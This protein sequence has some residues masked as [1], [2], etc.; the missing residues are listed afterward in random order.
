MNQLVVTLVVILMPGIF[1][2]I[3]CDKITVHSKW[4]SFKF[5]LYAL[6]LGIVSY[7]LLQMLM[8]CI[9]VFK[10]LSGHFE[11]WH[12]LHIWN[13]ALN[14]GSG[15]AGPE[16][17]IASVLAIPVA[18]LAS[19]S[20]NYKVFTRI[21]QWLRIST[22]YGDENLYSYFLNAT[23]IDWIY[24]RA[25]SDNLTYQGRVVSHSEND[26]MQELVL[27]DVSVFRY[28]DSAFLYNL[29][30]MYM[31]RPVGTL[32]IEAVPLDRLEEVK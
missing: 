32:V 20:V 24:V 25:I 2:A 14:S 10:L 13:A 7:A 18:L 9:D 4:T 11:Q 16:V 23:E 15:L 17:L 3:I 28:E 19:W 6:L 22:K 31:S 5:G 29:P 26:V 30:T 21:A 1:A 12:H 27:S 8:Y